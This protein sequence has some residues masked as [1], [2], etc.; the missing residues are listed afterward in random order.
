MQEPWKSFVANGLAEGLF[1][2]TPPTPLLPKI[3]N[4]SES[5]HANMSLDMTSRPVMN[6]PLPNCACDSLLS[7]S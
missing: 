7:A 5:G 6:H 1:S 2:Q 4:Q 3:F